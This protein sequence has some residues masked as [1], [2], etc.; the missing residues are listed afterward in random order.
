MFAVAG[1]LFLGGC[2]AQSTA[3]QATYAACSAQEANGA[4]FPVTRSGVICPP[5]DDAQILWAPGGCGAVGHFGDNL[6]TG[7]CR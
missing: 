5:K 4:G 2:A 3:G 1:A 7:G 6:S